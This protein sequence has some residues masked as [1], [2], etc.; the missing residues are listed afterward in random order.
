[1]GLAASSVLEAAF[2]GLGKTGVA[3]TVTCATVAIAAVLDPMLM[4]GAFGAFPRLGLAGA[5][6]GSAIAAAIGAGL[7]WARAGANV[8]G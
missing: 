1:M 7:F 6:V 3:L 8:R 4:L 2:R 5:A